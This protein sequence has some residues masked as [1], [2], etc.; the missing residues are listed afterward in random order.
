MRSRGPQAATPPA[1]SLTSSAPSRG[2]DRPPPRQ[3]LTRTSGAC[4]PDMRILTEPQTQPR[5]KRGC[6]RRKL[7]S[8]C[9]KK[10]KYEHRP[11]L[12][13]CSFPRASSN[14]DTSLCPDRG[15]RRACWLRRELSLF[16]NV[17]RGGGAP[18][19]PSLVVRSLEG[20][21]GQTQLEGGPEG[22]SGSG[23]RAAGVPWPLPSSPAS[24]LKRRR[25]R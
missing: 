15:F 23:R 9:D 7:G 13:L 4:G 1:G 14:L 2:S 25:E 18:V 17:S 5:E 20:G 22:A 24:W 8:T 16:F 6:L 12:I 10:Q 19:A 21:P 3:F 11:L